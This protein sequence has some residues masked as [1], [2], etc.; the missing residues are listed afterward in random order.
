M[1]TNAMM[2][3]PAVL[4]AGNATEIDPTAEPSTALSCNNAIEDGDG[5]TLMLRVALP[6]PA[7]FE[8]VIVIRVCP[9]TL[10]MPEIRPL[11]WSIA[12]PGGRPRALKVVG[13]W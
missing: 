7:A 11:L 6:V 9:V 3:L 8:A 12:S 4:L 5:V 2:R 1:R 10:S 13:S